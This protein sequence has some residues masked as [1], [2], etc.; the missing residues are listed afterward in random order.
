M[1]RTFLVFS[2][3][4]AGLMLLSVPPALAQE[5]DTFT[6]AIKD[7]RFEPSELEVPAGRRIRLV[8]DN[9]DPTPE[10]FES[11][12]LDVEKIISGNHRATLPL[13]PLQ[14]GSYEFVGEFHEK[15]AQGRLIAK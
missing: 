1:A 11:H 9:Q 3:A 8:V 5:P 7:H 6:L 2:L 15:T 4:L 14:P 10:E 12:L 13:G